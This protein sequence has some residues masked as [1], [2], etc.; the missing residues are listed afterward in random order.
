[1]TH[2]DPA[3][4]KWVETFDRKSHVTEKKDPL[5][6]K[7]GFAYDAAGNVTASVD[8]NTNRTEFTYD[9]R[10]NVLTKKVVA[11]NETTTWEYSALA[12]TVPLNKPTKQTDPPASHSG[13]AAASWVTNFQY[14]SGGNVPK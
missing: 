10:A 3:T 6:N 7:T 12:G 8:A 5:G 11:L 2:I 14:D 1:M 13:Q 9:S 4:K